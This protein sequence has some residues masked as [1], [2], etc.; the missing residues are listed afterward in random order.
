MK[1]LFI[2]VSKGDIYK[3]G[4]QWDDVKKF[5]S[6]QG[7]KPIKNITSEHENVLFARI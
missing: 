1:S 7:L 5:L 6:Q 3:N 4:S 2:E